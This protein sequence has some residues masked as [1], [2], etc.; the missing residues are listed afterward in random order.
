MKVAAVVSLDVFVGASGLADI[1]TA[2][3][4]TAD[5]PLYVGSLSKLFTAVLKNSGFC[6]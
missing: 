1:E 3:E 5:T 4:M 6:P 2:R